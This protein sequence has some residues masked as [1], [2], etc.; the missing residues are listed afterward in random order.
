MIE[1]VS[2]SSGTHGAIEWLL[3]YINMLETFFTSSRHVVRNR[4]YQSAFRASGDCIFPVQAR[5][6]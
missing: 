3:Q 5:T 6:Y 1:A 4:F 2:H